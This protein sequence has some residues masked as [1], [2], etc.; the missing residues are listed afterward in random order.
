MKSIRRLLLDTPPDDRIE[1]GCHAP[2]LQP[3]L[4]WIFLQDRAECIGRRVA[5][6][7]AMPGQHFV[8]HGTQ[9]EDVAPLIGGLTTNLLRRHV[10]DRPEDGAGCRVL[11][12]RAIDG[13]GRSD[14]RGV[15]RQA[16]VENLQAS[17]ARHEQ[18][19]RLQVAMDD[20]FFVRGGKT[21]GNLYPAISIALRAG[22][23]PASSRS[24]NVCPSSSSIA[25]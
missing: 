24:R 15:L 20:S 11:R 3:D 13:G 5:A 14:G 17:V 6:E 23:G 12:D 2:Y 10:S 21:M 16:E 18:V 4:G 9:R 7:R 25:A 8:E 1:R 22:I 19:L